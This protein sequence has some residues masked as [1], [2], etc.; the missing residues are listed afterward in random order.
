MERCRWSRDCL[1]GPRR[2]RLWDCGRAGLAVIAALGCGCGKPSPAV[3]PT[4]GTVTF[5]GRPAAG[6]TVEFS[7]QAPETRGLS[8]S[9]IVAADGG[10]SLRTRFAGKARDGA[11]AGPHRVVVV[12]PPAAVQPGP[13]APV[14]L[15]YADYLSS[16]LTAEV[17]AGGSNAILLELKR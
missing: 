5:E 12:P 11:V 10:F 16:G 8:A 7:S 2:P 9:G 15:R 13:V 1:P 17:V 4:G 3:H 14:P 6:F